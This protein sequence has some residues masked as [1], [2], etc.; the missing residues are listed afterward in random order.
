MGNCLG[1]QSVLASY[2]TR[3]HIGRG[4]LS[5][6]KVLIACACVARSASYGSAHVGFDS[7]PG[8]LARLGIVSCLQGMGESFVS[9]WS[10][11]VSDRR[12]VRGSDAVLRRT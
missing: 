10:E 3:P 8:F 7:F 1:E 12:Q 4:F 2:A 11:S 9:V 6:V 5:S